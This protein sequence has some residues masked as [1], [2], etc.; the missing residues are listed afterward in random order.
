MTYEL[1][2]LLLIRRSCMFT[3]SDCATQMEQS[4][5]RT[6]WFAERISFDL[7]LHSLSI[8]EYA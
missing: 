2:Q 8:Y 1:M 4:S 5:R 6:R 3:V 7:A